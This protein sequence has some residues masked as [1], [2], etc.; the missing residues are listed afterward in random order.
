VPPRVPTVD[1][2][3]D[4]KYNLLEWI[5]FVAVCPESGPEPEIILTS[6]YYKGRNDVPIED[7]PQPCL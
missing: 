5:I 2:F 1:R 4:R 3:S 7:E 6:L